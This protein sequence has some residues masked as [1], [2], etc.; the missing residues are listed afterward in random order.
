[1][2]KYCFDIDG[3]VCR[4]V[5]NKYKSSKPNNKVIKLINNLYEQGH[6]VIIFTSRYMGRNKENVKLAK[7]Q[8]YNFTNAQ[9]RNWGL[10]FHKLIFGKPSYDFFV[11]DKSIFFEKNWLKKIKLI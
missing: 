4:T 5:K 3:V 11:D 1:M 6:Y 2:K 8:G 7:K 10:K 9:L